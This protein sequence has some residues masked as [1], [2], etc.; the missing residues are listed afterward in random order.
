MDEIRYKIGARIR[1]FERVIVVCVILLVYL[2]LPPV[3]R[4]QIEEDLS[5]YAPPP[6]RSLTREEKDLL[7]ST[8]ETKKL[9]KIAL[10]LMETRMKRA[11]DADSK[12]DFDGLFIELGGFHGLMDFTLDFLLDKHDDGKRTFNDFKRFEQGLR[13]YTPRLELIRR[14]LPIKY[15]YYVRVL[16]KVLREARA[17]AIDPLFDDTV[18]RERSVGDESFF[19]F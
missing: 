5:R 1:G 16:I 14:D 3:G 17:R 19:I 7:A 2:S 18:L 11:E 8:S 10:Q 6:S 9:T 15:E 4:A 13:S 12:D